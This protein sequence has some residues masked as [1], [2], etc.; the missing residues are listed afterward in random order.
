MPKRPCDSNC[1]EC[2]LL[3][4]TNSEIL[5]KI[6]NKLLFRFGEGVYEIVQTNCP[7]LTVCCHCRIDDFCHIE[8]CQY[9][10]ENIEKGG[11]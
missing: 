2:S 8:G 10:E 9:T 11:N 7:N 3:N 1:N 4:S 6:F 5:T